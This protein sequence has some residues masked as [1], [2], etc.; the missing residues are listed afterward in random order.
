MLEGVQFLPY[1]IVRDSAELKSDV[2]YFVDKD[3]E[4]NS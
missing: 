4:P 2:R 3:E 1:L